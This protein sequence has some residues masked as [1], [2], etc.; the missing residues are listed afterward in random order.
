[1]LIDDRDLTSVHPIRRPINLMLQSYASFPHMT[2]EKNIS[3]G[4]EMKGLAK[5]A[6]GARFEDVVMAI[7]PL[8]FCSVHLAPD[9]LLSDPSELLRKT[10]IHHTVHP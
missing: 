5:P 8:L 7:D 3:F 1:M 10:I 4:L 9:D 2:V 6:I